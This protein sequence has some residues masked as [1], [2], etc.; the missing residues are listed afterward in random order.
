MSSP[1]HVLAHLG[2]PPEAIHSRSWVSSRDRSHSWAFSYL[3]FL[4]GRGAWAPRL[5]DLQV[6]LLVKLLDLVRHAVGQKLGPHGHEQ[7]VVA[8][9]VIDQRVHQFGRHERCV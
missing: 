2:A 6:E 5:K 1:S 9:A 4:L 7:T 8:G 3:H